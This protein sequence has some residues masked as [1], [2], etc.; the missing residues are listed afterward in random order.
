M[1]PTVTE[2][3]KK[4]NTGREPGYIQLKYAMMSE[5]AFRFFRGT[6][7][8]FYEDFAKASSIP[9]SPLTWNCGDLHIENFGSYK[10]DN[11]LVYFDLNDFDEAIL[12]PAIWELTRMV[13]SIFVAFDSLQL[14]PAEA[15]QMARLFLKVYADIL[16][17]GKPRYIEPQTA[18]GIVHAFLLRVEE[19]KQK[20]ILMRRTVKTSKGLRFIADKQ[21]FFKINKPERKVL[22]SHFSKWL[23]HN[24]KGYLKNC[25]VLDVCFRIAGTGSVGLK[26]YVFLLENKNIPNKFLLI[27]MKQSKAS[28]MQ[29]YIKTRQPSWLT[30]AE[31]I[32]AVQERMQ[33]VA[34]ALL[35]TIEFKGDSYVLKELQPMDDRIDFAVIEDYYE[36]I[37][38][39][40][41]DMALLTA[42][43]Q[44]R[45][46]G[47]QGSAIADK[48]IDFGKDTSWHQPVLDYAIAYSKQVKK[49]YAVYLKAYKAGS[50]S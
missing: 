45:S 46:S 48:L 2:R 43:A 42:S 10:G 47:R 3:I 20:E 21:R 16:I 29:P 32:I 25:D 5:N 14:K 22:I 12:A 49:D 13:A 37:H 36:D 19:R 39:V 23:K 31:R 11:R 44:L 30:D 7:H 1:K 35:S 6:C 9:A 41:E 34:P 24:R 33:N 38:I 28:S 40:I 15:L 27:D 26:R 4:S 18:K 17:K 50:F 8:L